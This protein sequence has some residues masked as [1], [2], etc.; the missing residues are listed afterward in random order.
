ML[1]RKRA[2]LFLYSFILKAKLHTGNL[3]L[4]LSNSYVNYWKC[5][6]FTSNV[7]ILGEI[8]IPF[9]VEN[10]TLEIES[11]RTLR[12]IHILILL[13]RRW[14]RR[15]C[16]QPVRGRGRSS[17]D[18]V[19]SYKCLEPSPQLTASCL[20]SRRTPSYSTY[21]FVLGPHLIS[22]WTSVLWT[23]ALH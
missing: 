8:P 7:C 19:W 14:R 13:I 4:R 23:R 20:K 5:R 18:P 15:D 6:L 17:W 2:H 22:L 16:L 1:I 10:L 11:W 3:V 21:T 9:N 12:E